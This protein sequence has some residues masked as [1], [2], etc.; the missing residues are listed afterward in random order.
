MQWLAT[1]ITL[2]PRMRAIS[3]SLDEAIARACRHLGFEALKPQQYKAITNFIES[4]DV[5]RYSP[6]VLYNHLFLVST[7][8]LQLSRI[9]H[10]IVM[11]MQRIDTY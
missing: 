10:S 8:G 6:E 4:E 1:V 9:G 3:N 5:L 11:V 2:Y 7:V